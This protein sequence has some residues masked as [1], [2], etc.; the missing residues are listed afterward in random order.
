MRTPT[1]AQ[2]AVLKALQ[3]Q[4]VLLHRMVA[5]ATERL[6]LT[7]Q[8]PPQSWYADYQ[9]RALLREAL[10]DAAHAGGVPHV[11][12]DQVRTRGD[13]GIRW[14]AD[15]HLHAPEPSDWDRILGDLDA[16]AQRLRAWTA[17]HTASDR[18]NP[19]ADTSV[20]VDVDRNLRALHSRTQAV[21]NLLGLTS[22]NGHDLW[23]DAGEWAQ[24]AI[25][26]LDGVPAEGLMQRWHQ[27]ARADTRS[28]ALQATALKSAGI[29]IDTAASLPAHEELV[30]AIRAGLT[31]PPLFRSA[32]TTT[33]ADID[34]ALDA[35]NL[36]GPAAADTVG[37]PTAAFSHNPTVEAGL[38]DPATAPDIGAPQFSSPG[39]GYGQ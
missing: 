9:E 26:S 7:G 25:A 11:W 15:L 29:P 14:R 34:A 4:T 28:Y 30:Q 10:L 35:A 18:I 31:L 24:A 20:V 1:Q 33:G 21:A 38:Y 13:R 36:T 37:G 16:D 32:T 27:L 8:N 19:A 2:A 23:G 5:T 3:N 6:Q 22:E 12:I 17:L 39:E